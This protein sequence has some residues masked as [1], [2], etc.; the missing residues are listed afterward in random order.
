LRQNQTKQLGDVTPKPTNL[1]LQ[2]V[3]FCK[4][5]WIPMTLLNVIGIQSL[6]CFSLYQDLSAQKD[7][8][9]QVSEVKE[10]SSKTNAVLQQKVKLLEDE[11]RR[12]L[13]EL[14]SDRSKSPKPVVAFP[15]PQKDSAAATPASIPALSAPAATPLAPGGMTIQSAPVVSE[16]SQESTPTPS[17]APSAIPPVESALSN[18]QRVSGLVVQSP[19]QAIGQPV[20]QPIPS[21]EAPPFGSL[22]ADGSVSARHADGT[23]GLSSP[24]QTAVAL[25]ALSADPAAPAINAGANPSQALPST[26]T[27]QPR[28][29]GAANEH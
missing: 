25:P 8:A 3:S 26:P 7:Q 1:V 17:V 9:R 2:V 23:P 4:A 24:P 27:D 13:S 14:M 11:K 20:L 5:V 19:P 16:Q 10:L 15:F 22:A 28:E 21:K 29:Q 18:P 6:F 12:L